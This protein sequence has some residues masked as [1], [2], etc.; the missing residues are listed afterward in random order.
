M[1]NHTIDAAIIGGGIAGAWALNLLQKRGYNAILLEASALGADQTLASQ[2]MIHGGLKYAL[3]GV[4]NGASEAI[5]DM[6]R[7]WRA[8]LAGEDDVDLRGTKLLSESYYMFA[9]DTALGRLTTFFASKA[10]RGRIDKLKPALWPAEFSGFD[11]V[12]YQL[13]DFVLDTEDLL[14]TLIAEHRGRVLQCRAGSHNISRHADGGYTLQLEDTNV[15]VAHLISCAGNGSGALLNDLGIDQLQVQQR[16]LKQVVVKPS[17][18][19]MLYAHCLTGLSS[20][21]PRLTITT[22]KHDNSVTWYLGGQL[23]DKGVHR[24]DAEQLA[25]ARSELEI[26]VPWLDWHDASFEILTVDR[27]EPKQTSGIKPDEAFVARQGDFIQCFPTKLTLTP[28]LGDKLLYVLDK[29]CF[30]EPLQTQQPL[31]DIGT[32]PW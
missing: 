12:V 24:S 27:A 5:A 21:E 2:G 6:P 30:A 11:G 26:C 16:P 15:R 25:K 7:R 17:H 9:Q 28:D 3:S 13:N 18:K 31:A 8:C 22:R 1:S 14:R 29:P 19:V 23:A 10:L 32:S 4:L 20:D